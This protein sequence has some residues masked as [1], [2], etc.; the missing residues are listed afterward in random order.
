M[1]SEVKVTGG[2]IPGGAMVHRRLLSGFY[3][4]LMLLNSVFSLL[5][6]C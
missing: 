3:R 5:D 6:A 1:D 2:G 4:F